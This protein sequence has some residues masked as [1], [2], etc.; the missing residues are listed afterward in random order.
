M[1]V[2]EPCGRPHRWRPIIKLPPEVE[3]EFPARSSEWVPAFPTLMRPWL[4]GIRAYWLVELQAFYLENDE[5]VRVSGFDP[6]SEVNLL[7]EFYEKYKSPAQILRQVM[8]NDP[9][10]ELNF[11]VFDAELPG[12]GA[13]ER[14]EYFQNLVQNDHGNTIHV[15]VIQVGKDSSFNQWLNQWKSSL[16]KG[17]LVVAPDAPWLS[18][19]YEVQ[20]E[21]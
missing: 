20:E 11:C 3:R 18:T 21:V 19:E 10:R 17:A 16:F 1:S 13:S 6:E 4:G 2:S 12:K 5:I 15:Q 14:C 7:G 9:A 8:M